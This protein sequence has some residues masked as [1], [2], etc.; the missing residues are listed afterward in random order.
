MS[1]II[2]DH[3]HH[4]SHTNPGRKEKSMSKTLDVLRPNISVERWRL[5]AFNP[6]VSEMAAISFF[7]QSNISVKKFGI[8]DRVGY[9]A[10][11]HFIPHGNLVY[12]KEVIKAPKTPSVTVTSLQAFEDPIVPVVLHYQLGSEW[13]EL[14]HA[15]VRELI[16]WD[17]MGLF[18]FQIEW[19]KMMFGRVNEL[20]GLISEI[21][22]GLTKSEQKQL[23]H[24]LYLSVV[25]PEV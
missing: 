24:W 12:E 16:L 3:L 4:V 14:Y 2:L 5:P 9:V 10:L 17:A 8:I 15:Y 13:C 21:G 11:C 7:Q 22:W 23:S 6:Q 18:E 1:T 25:N 19:G 20:C